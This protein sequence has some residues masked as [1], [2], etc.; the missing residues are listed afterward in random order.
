MAASRARKIKRG[1]LTA[2]RRLRHRLPNV[3]RTCYLAR[4]S[5][6]SRDLVAAEHVYI[7][8]ECLIGPGVTIERYVMLGPRVAIVGG[9]HVF[10]RPAVPIIFSG[11]PLL[12]PTRL[13]ADCWIGYGATIMAGTTVG[14]G[15]IVGA[16]AV[17]T[18]DVLPYAIVAGVPARQIGMR[19]SGEEERAVHDKMLS[20]PVVRG[21]FASKKVLRT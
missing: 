21:Q 18:Q 3:H 14:R 17:V 11:R 15:A 10:D 13:E 7:G 19:F 9:D 16:G 4:G 8:P 6:I 12:E 5:R 2:V 20:G 1:V